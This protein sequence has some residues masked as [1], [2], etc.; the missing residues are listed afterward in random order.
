[1]T[2][3]IRSLCKRYGEVAVFSDVTL[4]VAPGEFVAIV[5]ESGVG[6]ST[7]LNVVAGL[8]PVDAGRVFF[9]DIDRKSTRLNASHERLSRM[10]SSA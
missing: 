4:D 3:A 9:Q 5:G 6:K 10:P 8:E 2:L 1:M 7:L